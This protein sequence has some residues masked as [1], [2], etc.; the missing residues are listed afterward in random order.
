MRWKSTPPGDFNRTNVK[1]FA[2]IPQLMNC[3][4]WVWFETYYATWDEDVIDVFD[5]M[6]TEPLRTL[7]PISNKREPIE[8]D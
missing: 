6:H 4:T 2:F 8:L 3:G 1:R 7:E 5:K